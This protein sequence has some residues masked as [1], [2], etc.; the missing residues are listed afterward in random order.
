MTPQNLTDTALLAALKNPERHEAALKGLFFDTTWRQAVRHYVKKNSG[1]EEEAIEI[2]HDALIALSLNI[3]SG[4][5]EERSTLFTYFVGIA[6]IKWLTKLKQKRQHTPFESIEYA[7]EEG[8]NA[9]TELANQELNEQLDKVLKNIGE[10]CRTV[11]MLYMERYT[12][13]EIAQKLDLSSPNAAKTKCY[14]CRQKLGKYL[15]KHP[16][17]LNILRGY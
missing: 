12:N 6:K 13:A 5:F 17:W 16:K 3:R 1:T 4:K 2:F 14:E 11:L 8:Q 7:W 10:P 9:E 15:E